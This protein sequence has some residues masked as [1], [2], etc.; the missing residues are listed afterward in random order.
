MMKGWISSI[1]KSRRPDL[2]DLQCDGTGQVLANTKP[3]QLLK[4]LST[5]AC[6]K[7]FFKKIEEIAP[8]FIKIT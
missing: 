7:I 1:A 2:Y 3:W 8:S 5:L 4:I 6:K